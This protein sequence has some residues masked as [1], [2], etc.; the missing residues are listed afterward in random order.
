MSRLVIMQIIS[1]KDAYQKGLVRYFTGDPCVHGHIS[2]RHVNN[3]RCIDCHNKSAVKT[4]SKSDYAQ[5]SKYAI[6]QW[7]K[8]NKAHVNFL[9]SKRRYSLLARTPSWLSAK[10]HEQIASFYHEAHALSKLLGEW[11]EVDHIVPLQGK[12]VSGLHVPWNL[13]ILSKS[14]NSAKN[15]RWKA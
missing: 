13:Q 15:N 10:H 6:A 9:N 3:W 1:R 2:E 7:K 12:I 8:E 11:Y 5:K 4:R 14:E